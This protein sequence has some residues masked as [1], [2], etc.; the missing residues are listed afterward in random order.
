LK[1]RKFRVAAVLSG[2]A[3]LTALPAGCAANDDLTL[4]DAQAFDAY[5]LYY[6]GP[7][8]ASLP[9]EAI[10]QGWSTRSS[11]VFASRPPSRRNT[12]VPSV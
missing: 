2:L 12:S 6:S 3:L 10:V 5:R 8:V 11:G 7:E 4:A 9:L 1:L